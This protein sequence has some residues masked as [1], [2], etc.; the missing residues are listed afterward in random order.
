[1]PVGSPDGIREA[2]AG[3]LGDPETVTRLGSAARAAV[4]RFDAHAVAE[5]YLEAYQDAIGGE[6]RG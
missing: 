5:A 3:L 6:D 2:L 4:R 1:V